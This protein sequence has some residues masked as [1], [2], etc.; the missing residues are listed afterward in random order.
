VTGRWLRIAHHLPA[1]TRLRIPA[2][3]K[4]PPAC[5]RVADRLAAIEGVREV[6]VRPYTGSVLI[7]HAPTVALDTLVEV[8]RDTLAIDLVLAEG[9]APP[10]DP[11]LPAFSTL[12]RQVVIAVRKIDQDIRR[13]TDGTVDLGTLATL[14]LIGAG[15]SQIAVTGRLPLPPWFNLAWWGYRTFMTTENVHADFNESSDEDSPC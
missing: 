4:D 1:R 10:M 6:K 11:H 9:E 2:L 5:E 13:G 14:G 3:R 8:T 15:A 12:A 7:E